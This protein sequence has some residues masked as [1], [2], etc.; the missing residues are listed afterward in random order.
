MFFFCFK[1]GLGKTIQSVSV[2]H[3]LSTEKNIRGP[4]LVV[5]PLSTIAHWKR[6]V[7]HWTWMNIIV[8][9]GKSEDREMLKQYEFYFPTL[10][11]N[12]KMPKFNVMITTYE[13]LLKEISELKTFQWYEKKM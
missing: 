11:N 9:H 8:F 4:F 12:K 7:L 10:P 5:A 3:L 2:M 1:R 6:E 13:I